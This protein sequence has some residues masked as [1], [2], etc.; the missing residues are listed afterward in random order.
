VPPLDPLTTKAISPQFLSEEEGIEI[1]DRRHAGET[2]R[3]IAD[4]IKRVRSTVS[5]ELRRNCSSTGAYQPYR[6][7]E[8]LRCGADNHGPWACC[9]ITELLSARSA[10]DVDREAADFSALRV[11][12]VAALSCVAKIKSL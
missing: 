3:A 8:P 5:R 11:P 4:A 7:T 10:A 1:A 2:V 9:A 6:P 12:S